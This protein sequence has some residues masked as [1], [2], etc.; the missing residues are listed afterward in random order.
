MSFFDEL[1]ISS[2]NK[3]QNQ[4]IVNQTI[5]TNSI[6]KCT[7]HFED[8]EKTN[9]EFSGVEDEKEPPIKTTKWK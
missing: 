6:K 8:D 7:D 4:M 9:G 2:V 5:S 1:I 3:N